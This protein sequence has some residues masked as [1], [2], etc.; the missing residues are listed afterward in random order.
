MRSP[1]TEMV[2]VRIDRRVKAR[3]SKTLAAMGL[4]VS[5]A[6]RVLLTRVAAE[7]ALPFEVKVPNAATAAAM[8]EARK[9]NL[10]AFNTVSDLMADLNA[11]D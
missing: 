7:K 1:A 2:H 8:Q 6:V 4:S 5:D 10:S 9:G 3:A 11:D